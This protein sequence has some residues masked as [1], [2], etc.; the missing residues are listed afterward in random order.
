VLH[1]YSV[2]PLTIAIHRICSWNC[3]HESI[4]KEGVPGSLGA[5]MVLDESL[6]LAGRGKSVSRSFWGLHRALL[7]VI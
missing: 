1:V 4:R 5:A 6:I 7:W 2:P 3:K